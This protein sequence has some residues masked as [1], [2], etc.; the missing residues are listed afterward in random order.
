MRPGNVVMRC[1]SWGFAWLLPA[2]RSWQGCPALPGLSSSFF[3]P[4]SQGGR[5]QFMASLERGSRARAFA[6]AVRR[7]SHLGD[8]IICKAPHRAARE[9][10]CRL[11]QAADMG[12]NRQARHGGLGPMRPGRLTRARTYSHASRG[13]LRTH[14]SWEAS[15]VAPLQP[16]CRRDG[17][18]SSRTTQDD[19]RRSRDA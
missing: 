13:L 2:S 9:R 14:T 16:C 15:C 3:P 10:D 8:C 4:S 7:A 6:A 12:G 5:R 19:T 18:G 11:W 1:F 17:M